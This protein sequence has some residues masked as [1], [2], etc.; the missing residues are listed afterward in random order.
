MHRVRDE[1][2]DARS[3]QE[4]GEGMRVRIVRNEGLMLIVE[5]VRVEVECF[6]RERVHR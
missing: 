3:P 1:I 5:P 6:D 4:A 2:C